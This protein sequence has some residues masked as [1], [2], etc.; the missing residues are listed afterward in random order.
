MKGKRLISEKERESLLNTKIKSFWSLG[1]LFYIMSLLL[2][3]LVC[4]IIT[5][6]YA[7]FYIF[8]VLL[9]ILLFVMFVYQPMY[10]NHIKTNEI[11]CFDSKILSCKE[12]DFYYYLVEIE[13]FDG[14]FIEYKFPIEKKAKKEQEI[15]VV[16]VMGE[17][18]F[19]KYYLI[20]KKTNK[21]LTSKRTRYDL[22]D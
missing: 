12:S 16:M 4:M 13:G 5:G 15:T 20:D 6:Y 10:E 2:P 18:K 21:L 7:Y 3:F 8:I 17:N 1:R 9:L 14:N 22:L 19:N 11:Y